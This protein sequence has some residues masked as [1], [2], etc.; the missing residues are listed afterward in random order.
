[1]KWIPVTITAL[2]GSISLLLLTISYLLPDN[3]AGSGIG[4]ITALGAFAINFPG[5]F[6]IERIYM[7]STGVA[8]PALWPVFLGIVLVTDI[9]IYAALSLV[10]LGIKKILNRRTSG[11]RV[12]S[13]RCRV[14]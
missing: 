4:F 14:R 12:P 5:I 7:S 9:Y 8:P 1:M 3:G 11:S 2:H 6:T 10:V 13:T